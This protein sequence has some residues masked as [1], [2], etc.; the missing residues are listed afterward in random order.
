[1]K[2]LMIAPEPIFE[3]RGTPLSVVG[4]LKALCPFVVTIEDL[5]KGSLL[6]DVVINDLYTDPYP[7]E[8]HWYGVQYALLGPQFETVPP[9]DEPQED[10]GRILVTF[11]GTDPADLTRTA[12]EA[13]QI[14]GFTGWVDLVLGPGYAH[15]DVTLE[16]YGLEGQ[17]TR[18]APNL[19]LLMHE[20]DLA[21]TSAGRTV[22]E[23]MTQGIPTVSLCQNARELL[24]THAS[25]PYGVANLGLG[26]NVSPEALAAHLATLIDDH[27]LRISMHERMLKAVRGRSNHAIVE[28]ILKAAEDAGDASK[29]AEEC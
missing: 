21:I 24:H 6:A 14:L 22:T 26:A 9:A 12:L 16:A 4:R 11:G 28:R 1:M 17:L 18:S 13:L 8:S 15:G 25:S 10:V 27:R 20:T 5:G 19:P 2:I 7:S 29:T 3:P 23:L